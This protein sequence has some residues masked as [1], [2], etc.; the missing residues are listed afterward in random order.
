MYIRG[1]ENVYPPEIEDVICKHPDVMLA[2]VIAVPTK[3]GV[4]SDGPMS[5]PSRKEPEPG[6]SRSS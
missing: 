2:A 6:R 1:G 3:N 5:C 4:R